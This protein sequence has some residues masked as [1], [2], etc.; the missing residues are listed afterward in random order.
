PNFNRIVWVVSADPTAAALSVLSGQADVLESVRGDAFA[1]AR[2]SMNVHLIE[3]GSFDYAFMQFNVQRTVA[4]TRK[5]F[6]ERAVR[7]VERFSAAV[8]SVG[9]KEVPW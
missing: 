1:S 2:Q 8:R 3:Y 6:G 4:G 5:L 7:E 9:D